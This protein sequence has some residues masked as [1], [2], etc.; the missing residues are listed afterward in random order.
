MI[1]YCTLV[2]HFIT[3]KL[4]LLFSIFILNVINVKAQGNYMFFHLFLDKGLSDVRVT[5]I[6]QDK[7]GFMWFGTVNGLNRY[8]GYSIK[9]FYADKDNGLPSNNIR[10]V[11]SDSKGVLWIG[12]TKGPVRY[13]F[14]DE[15]FESA[16]VPELLSQ[17]TVYCF[18]EDKNGNI[19]A[20]TSDGLFCWYRNKQQWE[21]V[22]ARLNLSGRLTLIKGLLFFNKDILFAST[23]KKGLYKININT[24]AVNIYDTYSL[25]IGNPDDCCLSMY[26][27]EKL[28]DEEILLGT[29]SVGLLKFNTK[30]GTFSWPKGVLTKRDD[31]L[32][33]TVNQIKRDHAGRIWATSHYFRLT[34]YLPHSD[35]IVSIPED[36][37]N[38]YGFE[39]QNA[40]CI[41]EDRQHNIWIGTFLSGVY[42]FNPNKKSVRFYCGND[43][44][45]GALQSGKVISIAPLDSNTL[46]IGT[47]KGFS[48][49][50]RNTGAFLNY[51]GFALNFGD[52]PLEQVTSGLK[53]RN[54]NIW[55]GSSRLG[56]MHY[57]MSSQK[58][59]VFGRTTKPIRFEYDGVTDMLDLG[60]DSLL[61]IGY[62][63]LAVFHTKSHLS[64]AFRNDSLTPLYRLRNVN[65]IC[66]EPSHKKI[67]ISI[68]TGQLYEYDLAT[69]TL[70]ERTA[71]ID[72]EPKPSFIY[73]IAFDPKG[74]LWCAT[75]IG[76]ICIEQGKPVKVYTMKADKNASAEIKNI[77]PFKD[78]IWMTN[79]R[80]VAKLN[81][82]TGKMIL[83]GE[84]D[85]F[86][87]IQLFGHSLTLSPWQTILIGSNY[88]FYEIFPDR[89]K[90]DHIASSAYLTAF[91]VFNKPFA[92]NEPISLIKDIRLSYDQNFF[93]FDI[94]P[95]DYSE[96]NDI[97]YAYKLEGFDKSWIYLGKQRSGSYTNVPGGDYVLKLKV[98][99]N[100]GIWNEKGQSIRIHIGKPFWETWW[101]ISLA[102]LAVAA[103]IYAIYTNR[104][105]SIR[106]QARLRSDYEIRL[107][108]FENSALRTQMN[109]HFIFNS[110]NTINSFINRNEPTRANQY[111]SKFSKLIRL[112]LNHSREK[113]I[114]M[115][116]ELEVVDLYVSL[117]RI[118]F[119]NKFDYKITAS[120]DI[121]LD[122]IEIPP[123]I[124][125]PFVENAILHGLLPLPSGGMLQ[126][127]VTREEDHLLLVIE[128]NG[129]GRKKA[130]EHKYALG[131]QRKSHG[132]EIT[133]K[134]IELFN[135]EHNFQGKVM[136]KDLYNEAGEPLG[137]RV[138]IPVAWEE[139]F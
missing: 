11:F 85:G 75:N 20:G 50:K 33:N 102:V 136:I 66:F 31:I 27:M 93:S 42:H 125:Q 16:K 61:V 82:T 23:E 122:S 59:N 116:D 45:K 135:K 44:Q 48:L 47:N 134:R 138:E 107:N 63:Q 57:D 51:K 131:E 114:V 69:N 3:M 120:P 129:V 115:A 6:M 29:L 58:I 97:E 109:P 74:R 10:T 139:S 55:I 127:N 118:R 43:L 49:Y 41:Y 35:T 84:R 105:R 7:I 126:I 12:T 21:N 53:D 2:L 132:I 56:L 15:K 34:E 38:P 9:T 103:I 121:E 96:A 62:N 91:R 71:L 108:E 40:S 123:L 78:D 25:K 18:T 81:A 111:I 28:N 72:I 4:Y 26:G 14:P 137:T 64:R 80:T 68:S 76:A 100:S 70:S 88:G 94:S 60:G 37:Y 112:I 5:S 87:G 8:D 46:M 90:D 92:T 98:R 106:K 99:N 24:G 77:L 17:A 65:D 124:I 95:F 73:K 67:W 133:L 79:D 54:G 83:L 19:Y 117:E 36:V 52:K 130:G 13:I 32:F 1:I 104:V 113:K 30:A 39:S 110:L 86:S 101:F 119:D 89:I 22:S 128:D